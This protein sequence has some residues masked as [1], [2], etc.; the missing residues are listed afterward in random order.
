MQ[1]PMQPVV[2]DLWWPTGRTLE[3][4]WYLRRPACAEGTDWQE[5]VDPDG[6]LRHR[7]TEAER[8]Q[9]LDDMAE[10]IDWL[11]RLPP[12]LLI[13]VGCGPGWL[14]RA[15]PT[16]WDCCGVEVA[17]EAIEELNRRGLWHVDDLTDI[18]EGVADV[19]VAYHVIEH[20]QYPERHLSQMRKRL[21]KDGWLLIG[22]PDFASP[23]AVRFNDNY[24]MLHDPT[25]VSLFTLE[26]LHRFVRDH[27]FRVVD[28]RF[29][30]PTRYATPETLM[31][32]HDTSQVSPPWPG[33]WVT[34]Y[35]QRT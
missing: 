32:W 25:H 26:S 17:P 33:N 11:R 4:D 8:L 6:R 2:P 35:C 29:P 13:D 16:T 23:C 31:R 22:T 30:F 12:G 14:M 3:Q 21:R 19:V 1:I 18:A 34:L 27:G 9:W 28:M 5:S 20:L 15:M 10:E 24:R 7:L